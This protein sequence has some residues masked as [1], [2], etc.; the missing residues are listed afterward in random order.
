MIWYIGTY[1]AAPK[2]LDLLVDE[3]SNGEAIGLPTVD[4]SPDRGSNSNFLRI[5]VGGVELVAGE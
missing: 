3:T 4:K 1:F 5:G 2:G